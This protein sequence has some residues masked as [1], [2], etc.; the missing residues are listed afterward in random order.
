MRTE[1]LIGEEAMEKLRSSSVAVLGL[2]GVGS[3]CAEALARAGV[4]K[5]TL[6]DQDSVSETNINRQLCATYSTIGTEKAAA[7][8]SR[9]RDIAPDAEIIPM[10]ARYEAETRESFFMGGYDYIA[11]C[12]DLVACKLDLIQTAG[13]RG[14]P[15]ISALGTGNKLNAERLTICDIS[16]TIGCPLARVVRKEL[17]HRGIAHLDVVY[18][19]E[20]GISPSQPEAPPPG[21]RS[22]PGSVVWV[23]ATAGMLMAQHIVTTLIK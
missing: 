6:M 3:W 15:I 17:R 16:K 14:I 8:A 12:I 9:L 20:E 11:D 23:P 21:R 13:E 22:V 5:L 7:V 1:M 4:G 2:G 18:S 10:C 19:P